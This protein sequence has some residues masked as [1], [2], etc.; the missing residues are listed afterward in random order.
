MCV[1]GSAGSAA[2]SSPQIRA[3]GKSTTQVTE[4]VEEGHLDGSVLTAQGSSWDCRP[5]SETELV[6]RAGEAAPASAEKP[7]PEV[8]G[9]Q[10]SS[11]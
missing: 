5:H 6:Q 7:E 3:H 11:D 2:L 4:A 9:E 8:S 10:Q 1:L